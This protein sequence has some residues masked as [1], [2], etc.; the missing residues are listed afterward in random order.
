MSRLF[1]TFK[2]SMWFDTLSIANAEDSDH[3]L[4]EECI[5][6]GE[7]NIENLKVYKI[8]LL[9]NPINL[10]R[11]PIY[12]TLCEPCLKFHESLIPD[13]IKEPE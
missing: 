3:Y 9:V 7:S 2:M 10:R 4:S 13:D 11:G 6:C 12:Y 1:D 5:R 8:E